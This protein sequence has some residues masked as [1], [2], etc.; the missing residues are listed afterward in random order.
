MLPADVAALRE[1][2]QE[3]EQQLRGGA[4]PRAGDET[5][6]VIDAI[7]RV[8]EQPSAEL[9]GM[10]AETLPDAIRNEE[11]FAKAVKE[12][13]AELKQPAMA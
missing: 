4:G 1:K 5:F 13:L 6:T 8:K 3:R 9:I 7:A 11:R 10:Y 2:Y 12:R